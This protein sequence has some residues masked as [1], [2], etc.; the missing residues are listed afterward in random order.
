M[1]DFSKLSGSGNDFICIDGRDGRFDRII[2]SPQAVATFAKTLCK[3]GHGVGADGI[4]IATLDDIDQIAD[5][6]A[7]FFEADGTETFLCGNGTAC[8]VKWAVLNGFLSAEEARVLTPAGVV[9][10]QVL[11]DGYVRVCIPHP[12]EIQKDIDLP[13]NSGTLKCDFVIVGIGHTVTYVDDIDVVDVATLGPQIRNH[14]HFPQ[15]RGVNA[16]FVQ[17]IN[18]GE[19]AM[20]T[21]EYGVEAE[22]L[23]CGTGSAACAMLSTLRFGWGN[24][25]FNGDNP[26]IVHSRGGDVLRVHFTIDDDGQVKD[27]CLETLVRCA[28]TASICPDLAALATGISPA[29]PA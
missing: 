17:I 27:P 3:R 18:E 23:A 25:H 4:V 11:E 19:I 5:I 26:V 22:T 10:A 1:V 24:N 8:F 21:F 16:N 7:R 12:Q 15:P 28:Y 20:R 14:P 6:A 13:V 9:L 2:S 29:T